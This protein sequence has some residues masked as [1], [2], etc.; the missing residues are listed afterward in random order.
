MQVLVVLAH[1]SPDSLCAAAREVVASAG[2][3][4]HQVDLWD[5]QAAV[6]DPVMQLAD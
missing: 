6:F 2:A 5:L 4:G 1:P 3:A